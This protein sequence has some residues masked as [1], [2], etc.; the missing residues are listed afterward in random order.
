M[1]QGIV[2]KFSFTMALI[3]VL[4]GQQAN[5]EQSTALTDV[6]QPLPKAV[7][8][9]FKS[10]RNDPDPEQ[11]VQHS[12]YWVSNESAHYVWHPLIKDLGGALMGV[13]AD[14]IYL[15]AG[16]GRPIV[17]IPLDFDR[18]IA[19]LHYAYG[20]ALMTAKTPKEFIAMWSK[21]KEAEFLAAIQTH[22]ASDA[23]AISKAY[24]R[25]RQ[26]VHGRLRRVA[27]KYKELGI[28]TFLTTQ[29]D[30][31]YIQTMWK[32]QRVFPV[33]GDLTA[34]RAVL[35][36]AKALNQTGI[37][38]QIYYPSNA[39][40]Y[41]PYD[42]KY[43]RNMLALPFGDTGVVLRTRQMGFLGLAE[44]GDYHY[45]IQSGANFHY[46]LKNTRIP[47]QY[48]MLRQRTKTDTPGLSVM[49]KEPSPAKKPPEIAEMPE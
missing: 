16:W 40:H 8:D 42:A 20:A 41:F 45:N 6:N 36:L 48:R 10:I 43:R 47:D 33:C 12:H 13:G 7:Y 28:P 1:N 23:D 14:Q 39:E 30:Y 27:K 18:E 37:K 26:S 44:E 32:N 34:D 22:F 38:L 29:A 5:A 15:L 25:G 2:F 17:I 46:W 4:L 11:L 35:D 9:A 24:Q 21:C 19:R 49:D 3:L 31:E